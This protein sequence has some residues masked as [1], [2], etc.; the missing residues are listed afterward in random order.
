MIYSPSEAWVRQ[1]V[2]FFGRLSGQIPMHGELAALAD[3]R[4]SAIADANW[5]SCKLLIDP[6]QLVTNLLATVC[7][8]P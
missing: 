6:F 8:S 3:D 4:T 1:D 2:V 5:I 7:S